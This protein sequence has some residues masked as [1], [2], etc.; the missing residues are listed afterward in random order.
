MSHD[1][2]RFVIE[3]RCILICGSGVASLK[4]QNA[5]TKIRSKLLYRRR[6]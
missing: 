5:I 1:R 3:T 4:K 2:Q 6:A